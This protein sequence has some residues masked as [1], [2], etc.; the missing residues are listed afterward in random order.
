MNWKCVVHY[1]FSWSILQSIQEFL[2]W[3]HNIE[4]ELNLTSIF[5]NCQRTI[6]DVVSDISHS[7]NHN[8]WNTVAFS[9]NTHWRNIGSID[10]L[11]TFK[12]RSKY[13]VMWSMAYIALHCGLKWLLMPPPSPPPHRWLNEIIG[14]TQFPNANHF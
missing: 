6:V 7:L 10:D 11:R 13:I 3:R 8:K 1:H 5:P 4:C 14:R 2:L 9:N 12:C